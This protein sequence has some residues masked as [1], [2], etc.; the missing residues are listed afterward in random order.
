MLYLEEIKEMA[1]GSTNANLIKYIPIKNRR[2]CPVFIEKHKN[3][4]SPTQLNEIANQRFR[5]EEINTQNAYK[6]IDQSNILSVDA[7]LASHK[8]FMS[9]LLNNAGEYRKADMN[10]RFRKKSIYTAPPAIFIPAMISTLFNFLNNT[11][12]C[13]IIKSCVLYNQIGLV[14]P[15]SDGNGRVQRYWFLKSLMEVNPIFYYLPIE[16]ILKQNHIKHIQAL[17]LSNISDDATPIIEMMLETVIYQGLKS[18]FETK[19]YAT[20]CKV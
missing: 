13:L 15:F 17:R 8:Q 1:S 6:L 10:I 4:T 12:E 7:F 11:E 16:R 19:A 9:N 2:E 18:L 3:I 5:I 14:H 20:T